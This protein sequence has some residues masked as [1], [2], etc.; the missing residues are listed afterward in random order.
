[1]VEDG[2][3]EMDDILHDRITSLKLDRDR[4]K[5]SLER[6]RTHAVP[7]ANIPPAVIE[8]FGRMMR[9]NIATGE[10]PFRKAYLKSV[11]DQVIVDDKQIRIVGS[12]HMV[13]S[14]VFGGKKISQGVRS[15]ERKWRTRQDSNL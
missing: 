6:I 2:S 15:F 14:A 12:K 11:V 8:E 9:E 13:E 5:A 3:A 4:L 10:I 1:M 7:A